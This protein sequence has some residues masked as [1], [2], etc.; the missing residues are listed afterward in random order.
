M[1]NRSPE[2]FGEWVKKRRADRQITLRGFA[3]ASGIDPGN[4]SRYERGVLPPPQGEALDRI[5]RALGL[6]EGSSE[7]QALHDLAA[8]AAGRIPPDLAA[9]PVLGKRLPVLFR[10]ARGKKLTREM[11]LG[12]ADRIRRS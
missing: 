5:S 10:V 6:E 2:S 9:D 3:E 7:W 4:L 12:L 11:L 8:I 1:P